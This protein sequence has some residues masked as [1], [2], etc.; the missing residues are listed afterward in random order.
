ME[1]AAS[2]QRRLRRE[3]SGSVHTAREQRGLLTGCLHAQA[4]RA[5][6]GLNC[7]LARMELIAATR[8]L[9]RRTACLQVWHAKQLDDAA[10][11][12]AAKAYAA[13]K[14]FALH[15]SIGCRHPRRIVPRLA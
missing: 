4:D 1:P 11:G 15:T 14:H 9:S 12:T 2:R 13:A 10:A 5:S 7:P 6:S 8:T 3:L